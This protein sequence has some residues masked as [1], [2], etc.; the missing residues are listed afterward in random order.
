MSTVVKSGGAN[1]N[2]YEA[3][4]VSPIN[5]TISEFKDSLSLEDQVAL[6]QFLNMI[7]L[8]VSPILSSI[9]ISDMA[10]GVE[11]LV[12]TTYG[13][14][15]TTPI[16]V[17]NVSINGV[18]NVVNTEP[19][20]IPLEP[21]MTG[22][23]VVAW[24]PY[25]LKFYVAGNATH[26]PDWPADD[27]PQT[28]ESLQNQDLIRPAT[29]PEDQWAVCSWDLA[30]QGPPKTAT[31]Q[32]L[33]LLSGD[34]SRG[35][36]PQDAS[37]TPYAIKFTQVY[38][39]LEREATGP[40]LGLVSNNFNSIKCFGF[41][42]GATAIGGSYVDPDTGT[43]MAS[44]MWRTSI[45][46]AS[47]DLGASWNRVDLGIPGY[48]SAIK[49]VGY[50]WY[51]AVWNPGPVQ[52]TSGGTSSLFFASINFNVVSFLDAWN[53]S[54]NALNSAY[55][56]TSIDATV[57]PTG[58]CGP[59]FEPDPQNPNVCIKTCPDGYSPFGTLCVQTCPGPYRETGVPNE[60]VPDSRNAKLVSPTANGG[61]P[62]VTKEQTG[63]V[64][65]IPGDGLNWGLLL[66]YTFLMLLVFL[67]FGGLLKLMWKKRK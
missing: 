10:Y 4:T 48:V 52:G 36:S 7:T 62:P 67:L 35:V 54:S 64:S 28:Q 21:L 57:S 20:W 50:A 6:S 3:E 8:R 14:Y 46:P 18:L 30:T 12:V 58:I 65:G 40:L 44:L 29:I 45:A 9:V 34:A 11:G 27:V 26:T 16:V 41:S 55:E 5:S 47:N 15:G 66:T 56:V 33:M 19:D 23:S 49:Y 31:S 61:A 59:G 22:A 13:P 38:Q 2:Y 39:V 60:C 17:A 63:P 43:V 51:I 25:E 32:R 37:G 1:I 42:P 53:A 24:S